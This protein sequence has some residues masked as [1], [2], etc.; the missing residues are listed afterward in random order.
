[1]SVLM[2]EIDLMSGAVQVRTDRQQ[3]PPLKWLWFH[4]R[5]FAKML[6][7]F[8]KAFPDETICWGS[9]PVVGFDGAMLGWIQRYWGCDLEYASRVGA[10]TK[11]EWLLNFVKAVLREEPD[12]KVILEA[13][14]HP[15]GSELSA[16]DVNGLLALDDWTKDVYWAMVACDFQLGVHVVDEGS[17]LTARI[18]WGVNGIW[19]ELRGPRDLKMRTSS[20]TLGCSWVDAVLGRLRK[21]PSQC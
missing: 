7:A 19:V 14:S 3:N 6:A 16:T 13:H 12:H 4:W 17:K 8:T 5:F 18:P 1:M 11:P 21:Q 9:G 10:K 2:S 20:S 15:I